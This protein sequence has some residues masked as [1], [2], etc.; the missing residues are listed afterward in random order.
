MFRSGENF[1][2]E[3]QGPDGERTNCVN[4]A[5][6]HCCMYGFKELSI[7]V[8]FHSL[9][10][11]KNTLYAIISFDILYRIT[12]IFSTNIWKNQKICFLQV[13]Y[14][15]KLKTPR[16][17]QIELIFINIDRHMWSDSCLAEY[18]VRSTWSSVKPSL[19]HLRTLELYTFTKKLIQNSEEKK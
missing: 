1:V 18:S 8:S 12:I 6:I 9:H 4:V 16:D 11:V 5:G 14:S 3:G 2:K 10:S 7:W 19:S 15:Q 17:A 13:N